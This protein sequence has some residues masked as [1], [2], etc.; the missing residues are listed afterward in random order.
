MN[1]GT[2]PPLTLSVEGLW[3]SGK[4]SF[5]KQLQAEVKQKGA[6]V[7]W[8]GLCPRA[9]TLPYWFREHRFQDSR[10]GLLGLLGYQRFSFGFRNRTHFAIDSHHYKSRIL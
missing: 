2:E 10:S 5:M 9:S 3:G 1:D 6:N 7:V 8:F 4:S